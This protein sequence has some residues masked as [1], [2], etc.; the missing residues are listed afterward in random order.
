MNLRSANSGAPFVGQFPGDRLVWTGD[1]WSV[2]ADWLRIEVTPS[3]SAS[4]Q[5]QR[6]AQPA[7]GVSS[8]VDVALA[9]TGRVVSQRGSLFELVAG[10]VGPVRW[11]GEGGG[12]Y[13]YIGF[14]WTAAWLNNSADVV[15]PFYLGMKTGGSTPR[16]AEPTYWSETSPARG[17]VSICGTLPVLQGGAPASVI[18]P[19][20]S[21]A[22][23]LLA[24]AV[25]WT[26][27]NLLLWDT[28]YREG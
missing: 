3:Y 8:I 7:K 5:V 17:A 16:H 28:G 18:W 11:L 20:I 15:T 10:D 23:A 2:A 24:G 12:A 22:G 27:Q 9:S 19:V 14:C 1:H 25:G 6:I 26:E 13:A 21:G 4:N